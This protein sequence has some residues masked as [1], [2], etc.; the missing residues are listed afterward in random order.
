MWQKGPKCHSG[1]L[2]AYIADN[3]SI[4]TYQVSFELKAQYSI[5][6]CFIICIFIY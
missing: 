4:S 3:D 6:F 5:T 2:S 1:I